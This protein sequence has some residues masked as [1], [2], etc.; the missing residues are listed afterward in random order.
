M[1]VLRLAQA[2]SL[3]SRTFATTNDAL[4]LSGEFVINGKAIELDA[5]DSPLNSRDRTNNA[6][7]RDSTPIPNLSHASTRRTRTAA[8]FGRSSLATLSTPPGTASCVRWNSSPWPATV[9]AITAPA[10]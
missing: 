9:V 8:P 7:A 3:S 4:N 5:A 1:E 6:H 10:S 2:R